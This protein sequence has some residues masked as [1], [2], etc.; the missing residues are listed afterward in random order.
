MSSLELCSRVVFASCARLWFGAQALDVRRFGRSPDAGSVDLLAAGLD[1]AAALT[2]STGGI[3]AYW[4]SRC[5][6]KSTGF[7]GLALMVSVTHNVSAPSRT[8]F[9]LVSSA[10]E[11]IARSFS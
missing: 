9:M 3:W 5:A 10:V 4:M 8:P 7:D 11:T 2:G 1:W 6:R